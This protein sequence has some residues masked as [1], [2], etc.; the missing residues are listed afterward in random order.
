MRSRNI[1][2]R[3]YGFIKLLLSKDKKPGSRYVRVAKS[4]NRN[5]ETVRVIALTKNYREFQARKASKAALRNIANEQ[6]LLINDAKKYVKEKRAEKRRLQIAVL[7]VMVSLL[8]VYFL[9]R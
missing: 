9:L 7:T 5:S 3:E 8:L 2:G 1:S 6:K 4:A